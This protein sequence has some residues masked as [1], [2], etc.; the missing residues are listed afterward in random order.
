MNIITFG[1]MNNQ[2]LKIKAIQNKFKD[3]YQSQLQDIPTF[4]YF[5][6]IFIKTDF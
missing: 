3:N 5:Q 1:L 6:F 2:T 4:N